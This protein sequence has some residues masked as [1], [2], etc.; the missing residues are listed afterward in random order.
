MKTVNQTVT[1]IKNGEDDAHLTSIYTAEKLTY[2]RERF[3]K[4]ID[5]FHSIHGTQR[6]ISMFSVSGK[7]E[8]PDN[9]NDD[10]ASVPV[11]NKKVAA[12]L[13]KQV[14]GVLTV[15][16][17][18]SKAFR[19]GQTMDDR[20]NMR[21]IHFIN[22]NER[23]AKQVECLKKGDFDSLFEGVKPSGRSSFCHLQNLFT[24]KNVSE[25]SFSLSLCLYEKL[26]GGKKAVWR[27]R[28]RGFAGTAQEFVPNEYVTKFKAAQESVFGE[29]ACHVLLVR[30][31]GACK[32]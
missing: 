26:L 3:L 16:S 14:L 27:V 8:V 21:A 25:Q 13:D 20:A 17:I 15:Y 2:A 4:A 7:S 19:L 31:E 1:D 5:E 22:E 23:V 11:K 28:G 12:T 9:H 32:I 24:T 30:M 18:F 29:G 6:E 10:Y